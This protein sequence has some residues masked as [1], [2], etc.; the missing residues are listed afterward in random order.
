MRLQEDYKMNMSDVF[1]IIYSAE[2]GEPRGI[3]SR[4]YN[5]I[6]FQWLTAVF[7]PCLSPKTRIQ[8]WAWRS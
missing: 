5:F 3:K 7:N 4:N 2:R 6:P 8:H 1:D